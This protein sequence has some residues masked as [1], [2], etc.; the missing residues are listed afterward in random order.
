MM[1]TI[2]PRCAVLIVLCAFVIPAFAQPSSSGLT[3]LNINSGWEFR[4]RTA[5]GTTAATWRA[6]TVPGVVDTDLLANKLIP[7]P[8]YR[9]NEAKL[10]WIENADWEYRT[11][12]Q[13]TPEMLRRRHIELVFDGLDGY[14]DVYL[15]GQVVLS[16]DNAFRQW[17]AEVNKQLRA[18][19][20]ELLVV[21]PSPIEKAKEI[22]AKDPWRARTGVEEKTY[23]R[24]PAY[25][26]GWDWGPRFV[27]SGIWRPAR[28]EMWDNAR[29]ADFHIRQAD[30]NTDNAHLVAEIEVIASQNAAA[31][32]AVSYQHHGKKM[33]H[34]ADAQLHPGENTVVIPFSIAKPDL[35]FPTGYG[36]QP[37][38]TFT[39]QM[40]GDDRGS[41]TRRTGLRSVVLRRDVDQWGRSFEFIVNGIPIFGK[42]A[43]VIPFDSFPTRVTTAQYRHILESARDA[44][45]KRALELHPDRGGSHEGMLQLNAVW[46]RI[47]KDLER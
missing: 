33:E 36:S 24:K 41:A 31:K 26:Y 28:L 27:N 3:T 40:S 12:I 5:Q 39:L 14:A 23:I 8:F 45:R 1:T 42:G 7:D 20:N 16:A 43:D 17:R 13:A 46:E 4:Q 34:T 22:A 32:F 15:N 37:L 44:Y 6:A 25:E 11:T 47:R 18:G 35:W 9:D 21:F 29:I 30:I 10:Q 19:A 38:Y 2:I